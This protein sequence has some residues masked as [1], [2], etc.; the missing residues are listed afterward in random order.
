MLRESRAYARA[1]RPYAS[2][3]FGTRNRSRNLVVVVYVNTFS[4]R[5]TAFAAL[6]LALAIPAYAQAASASGPTVVYSTAIQRIAGYS[7]P[8]S[9]R[10]QIR[11]SRTGIISGYYRPAD[12]ND[13][14][15]V[16][17]GVQGTRVW[18]DIG[19]NGQ[20]RV[21]GR[22]NGGKIVGTAFGPNGRLRRFTARTAR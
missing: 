21:T 15:P 3:P 9:G 10:L 14:V 22:M 7:Y 2:G 4:K 5:Q 12:N 1:Q 20:T 13:F 11:T 16:T 19:K 6:L 17:G 18:L 8:V